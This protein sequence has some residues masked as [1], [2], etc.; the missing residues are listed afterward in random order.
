MVFVLKNVL[1]SF[2]PSLSGSG[3][4]GKY[5]SYFYFPSNNKIKVGS[6]KAHFYINVL[7]NLCTF[8]IVC[9]WILLVCISLCTLDNYINK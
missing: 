6:I 8:N 5:F 4:E 2:Q 9:V 1:F 3:S 7:Y